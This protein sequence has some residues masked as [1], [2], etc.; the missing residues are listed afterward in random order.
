MCLY[1]WVYVDIA[2]VSWQYGVN[3]TRYPTTTTTKRKKIKKCLAPFFLPLFLVSLNVIWVCESAQHTV[4]V[5]PFT[6]FTGSCRHIK[7]ALSGP[8]NS[9]CYWCSTIKV[10]QL[11]NAHSIS[12][13]ALCV[14]YIYVYQLSLISWA[15]AVRWPIYAR[16]YSFWC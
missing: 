9:V 7:W 3:F 10:L 15:F 2:T 4:H 8:H 6:H 12:T 11:S 1:I 5:Q 14:I 13:L 16:V